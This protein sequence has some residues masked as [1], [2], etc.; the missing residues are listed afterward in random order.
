M[1]T[2]NKH[3][4]RFGNLKLLPNYSICFDCK[5]ANILT[6]VCIEFIH[7]DIVYQRG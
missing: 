2:A 4:N 6:F 1:C 7:I 3:E 5:I